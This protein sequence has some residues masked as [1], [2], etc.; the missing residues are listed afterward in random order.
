M[1]PSRSFV[2]DWLIWLNCLLVGLL[3]TAAGLVLL[4]CA[5]KILEFGH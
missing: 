2:P 3:G 1:M 4:L 5:K